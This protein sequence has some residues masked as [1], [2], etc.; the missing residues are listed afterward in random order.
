[1]LQRRKRIIEIVKENK[2]ESIKQLSLL[3]TV[4]EMTI[5]RDIEQLKANQLVKVVAGAVLYIGSG[6]ED[7]ESE[8]KYDFSIQKNKMAEEKIAIGKYV[9]SIIEKEDVIF[10]DIGTTTP[11]II[12]YL[13]SRL[14]IVAV[15]C[16]LN[17]L[18]EFKKKRI[19][20][21]VLIGGTYHPDIQ[22]FESKEG[23][24]LLS[25]TRINKAFISAAGVDLKL[26]ITCINECEVDTK[27]A[28]M[29]VAAEKYLVVDSSKFGV[30]K[31]NFFAEITAFD[32]I[33]TDR[34]LSIEWQTQIE[35]LGIRLYLV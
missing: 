10:I 20:Q 14:P 19:E 23:V 27:W 29:E 5:R 24:E 12:Q 18:M 28:A 9:A 7:E 22:M 15:C 16:T 2:G 25:R 21:L 1:M 31:A 30:V 32:A 8:D 35:E 34:N 6:M 17:A 4:T 3:L 26:G 11:T 13:Q 33:V